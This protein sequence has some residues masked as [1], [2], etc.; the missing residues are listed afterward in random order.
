MLIHWGTE[1]IAEDSSLLDCYIVLT[2][3]QLETFQS[4]AAPSTLGLGNLFLKC[5]V[6]QDRGTTI[7]HN[8]TTYQVT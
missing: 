4:I 7:L 1:E 6:I 3:E 8:I 5:L 2:G